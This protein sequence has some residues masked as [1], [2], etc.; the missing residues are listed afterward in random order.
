MQCLAR[1]GSAIVVASGQITT[2]QGALQVEFFSVLIRSLWCV[3]FLSK[4]HRPDVAVHLAI[5]ETVFQLTCVNFDKAD[6]R[7]TG[8][9]LQLLDKDG[10]RY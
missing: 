7:G 8:K 4:T 5:D 9:P 3:G 6:G 2:F 10:R 1:S